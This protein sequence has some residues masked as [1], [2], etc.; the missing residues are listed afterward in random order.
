MASLLHVRLIALAKIG[1]FT[2]YYFLTSVRITASPGDVSSLAG[3]YPLQLQQLGPAAALAPAFWLCWRVFPLS[4]MDSMTGCSSVGAVTHLAN[5]MGSLCSV[6][7]LALRDE[8]SQGSGLNRECLSS[9]C[10]RKS[11][12]QPF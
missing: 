1:L 2:I 3:G 8:S 9:A 10:R 12:Q 4:E 5:P 11:A 6:F 7:S